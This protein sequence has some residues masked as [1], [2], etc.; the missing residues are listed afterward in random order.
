M[1]AAEAEPKPEA[2]ATG[3][4]ETCNVSQNRFY[5]CDCQP[6]ISLVFSYSFLKILLVLLF[7]PCNHF[8]LSVPLPNQHSKI[9]S[10]RGNLHRPSEFAA[11]ATQL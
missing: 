11:E 10:K 2:E 3:G 7:V 5:P 1:E 4:M 8:Y 6:L 9:V